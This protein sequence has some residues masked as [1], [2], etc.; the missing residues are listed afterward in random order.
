MA[1]RVG[2]FYIVDSNGSVVFV[3]SASISAPIRGYS[4]TVIINGVTVRSPRGILSSYYK[5]F[6]I[7]VS[8][9]KKWYESNYTTTINITQDSDTLSHTYVVELNESSSNRYSLTVSAGNTSASTSISKMKGEI[10]DLISVS[11]TGDYKG[12]AWDND[13]DWDFYDGGTGRLRIY[14]SVTAG[15]NNL[16]I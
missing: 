4:G 2:T 12:I 6:T 3:S 9:S 1:T 11:N 10:Y 16:Y 13:S 14:S 5:N 15:I 7:K 8:Y